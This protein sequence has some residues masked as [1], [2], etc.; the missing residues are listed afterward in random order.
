[1][2]K[3]RNASIVIVIALI[4][5]LIFAS[6]I[7]GVEKTARISTNSS[8]TQ[9]TGG[10]SSNPSITYDGDFV[11]FES[12]ATDLVASDTN[13]TTDIFKKD[14]SKGTTTRVSTNSS[15]T[16]AT[17]ISTNAAVSAN[18]GRYVAF[19]STAA[20]LIAGGTATKDIYK[21]DTTGNTTTLVSADTSGAAADAASANASITDGGRFVTFESTAT[22]LI[23]G[24]NGTN[25]IYKRDTT[26]NTTTIVSTDSSSTAGN[27]ASANASISADGGRYVAFESAATNLVANDTNTNT[28]IFRK[29]TTTNTTTRI[30]TA[31]AGTQATGGNSI[32]ASISKDG[33]YIAFESAATNLVSGDTNGNTDIFVKDTSTN[34]TT[35]L[36][37]DASGTQSTGGNSTN[38]SISED[39]R[40]VSFESAA[41]NLVSGDTNAATDI[42]IKD[43][44][45]G[46]ISRVS[47]DTSEV[48][49]NAAANNAS[50]SQYGQY[51]AYD[52]TATNLVTGDTN[53]LTDVFLATADITAPSAPT[54]S[55]STHKSSSKYYRN[56]TL[57][58]LWSASDTSGIGGYSYTLDKTRS[59]RPDETS[60]GMSTSKTYTSRGTGRW[61][62]HLRTK[63]IYNNWS[64]TRHFRINI[65]RIKP[66][67][68]APRKH[69]SKR[70]RGVATAKIYWKVRDSY[71]GNKAYVK[72]VVKKRVYS[73][74]RRAREARA[75]RAFKS[76]RAK[77]R[78]TTNKNLARKYRQKMRMHKRRL[79]KARR[80]AYRRVKTINYK[81]TR[82]NRLRVYK[83]R[84][85]A[86][87]KFKFWVMARDQARN[88]QRN[89]ARNYVII[90]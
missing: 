39:G 43:T 58:L 59:T 30:S 35:R 78:K 85:R 80:Q 67:T 86:S 16:Q 12:G 25:D 3:V 22:D 19:E 69:T 87:G 6:F 15:G 38:P 68:Y 48:Q 11:A 18:G 41:T 83:W 72:I 29:D 88:P 37:T 8:G 63:D 62:F 52:S 9:A 53:S 50:T 56:P 1:M 2:T 31:N 60:E 82:I 10:T 79:N 4:A 34:T 76:W 21:K 47:T 84:T 32:N 74:A 14:V 23:A 75:L 66:K 46:A 49:S 64:S 90:R 57:K 61:Y 45:S 17:G 26:G 55:S 81:W 42:F 7:M 40:H 27:G 54:V 5:A 51:V 28:D 33:R 77:A 36:S 89:V 13:G 73:A 71:T 65:D 70:R 24:G 20:D 44:A